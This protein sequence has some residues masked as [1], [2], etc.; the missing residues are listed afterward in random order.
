[1]DKDMKKMYQGHKLQYLCYYM[2]VNAMT[3]K[4]IVSHY[5]VMIKNS[6]ILF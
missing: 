5:F 2:H 6:E 4:A 1:M 3:N